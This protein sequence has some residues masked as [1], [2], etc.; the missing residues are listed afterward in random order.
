VGVTSPQH[1]P[2]V[3]DHSR[4][5]PVALS[6]HAHNRIA[7][8]RTDDAWLDEVWGSDHTRVLLLH[9]PRL[10]VPGE[11]PGSGAAGGSGDTAGDAAGQRP[12]W[13]AP[14]DAPA[15]QRLLLGEEDGAVYFALVTE[16]LPS[17][18]REE[19]LRTFVQDLEEAEAALVLHAVALA[20]WHAVNRYCPRCGSALELSQA[21]HL[22][23]CSG[24][25]KQQFPRTDP[26]VIM[27]V[28]DAQDRC[29]LGRQAR[30]PEGRYSTLAGFVEPGESLEHAVAREVEEEVGVEIEAVDY[31]GNQPWP[32]P[33][34]L[35][36]GFFARARTTEISV[37]G[38]EIADARWFTREQMLAEAEAGT[39]RLPGGISIS[40]SL[41]ETWYG[42]ELPGQW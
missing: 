30:W 40:R 24:C 18:M 26:A 29:L 11:P 1:L 15:G 10:L 36:V 35:M 12:V 17:G 37:D 6:L 32:F 31:F 9:G 13:V 41:I 28:T 27:L 39:L 38:A 33:A 8:R 34:S 5:A 42:A 2:L 25:G 16:E 23:V 20:E 19:Q 14:S 3:P 4:R 7:G 21:G 22:M